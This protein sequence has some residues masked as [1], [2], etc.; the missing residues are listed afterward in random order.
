[1]ADKK[2]KDGLELYIDLYEL[3]QLE[4]GDH[5][6]KRSFGLAHKELLERPLDLLVHWSNAHLHL[7]SQPRTSEK[8]L[9]MLSGATLFLL[10]LSFSIGVFSGVGL[11]RYNG[12]EPVNLLYFLSAVLLLPM[13]TMFTA[14]IAMLRADSAGATLIHLSPAYWMENLLL[15]LPGKGRA[16][17]EKL[18]VNPLLANW[19]AIRRSQEL[20]L[21]FSC[22]LF[23]ALL[24]V[25]ASEDIAFSWST[26][27]HITAEEFHHFLTMVALPWK[28]WLPQALPSAELIEQSHY[29]RLGGKLSSEMVHHAALLG[30]WWKFLAMTTLFYAVFLRFLFFLGASRGLRRATERSI[31][32]L[33]GIRELL[34][35]MQEPLI[36]TQASG[37]EQGIEKIE[38]NGVTV[39]EPRQHY[40]TVIGWALDRD[41]IAL[42]NEQSGIET[43]HLLVAGGLHSLQEDRQVIEGARGEVLLYVKA[44]EPPTMDFV[45]FLI[46]LS[47]KRNLSI[48][49]D[50][51]G[52]P[53]RAAAATDAE[54]VIWERKIAAL[55][56]E[57]VRMI[58]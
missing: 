16:L 46:A 22:G 9:K 21:A 3:M 29:F 13:V 31:L 52:T 58:R 40:D 17:I 2:I 35:E 57:N 39:T 34:R 6:T 18:K 10:I 55:K 20:A 25:V 28:A 24:L 38:Q 53:E 45:D 23:L 50:P 36:T 8:L 33:E 4:R 44:W 42:Q 19:I 54:F 49:V 1:M 41:T 11:L 7:L 48:A 27:L 26:T 32:S 56:Q 37:E 14:L 51:L 15:L 47:E 30:E 43:E 5:Q 12:D